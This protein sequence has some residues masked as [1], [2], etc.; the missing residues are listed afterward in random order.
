MSLSSRREY[1]GI[2]QADYRKA[3]RRERSDMLDEMA[4]VTGLNRKYIIQ[5]MKTDLA[6]KP[7]Q[8]QRG[9][10]YGDEVEEA[11]LYVADC[12]DFICG[13]RLKPA[14]LFTAKSLERHGEMSLSPQVETSLAKISASTIDRIYARNRDRVAKRLPRKK[15]SA[16][17]C[18]LQ[19]VPM[20]M[21]DWDEQ[22]PGHLEVDTVFH[23]GGD[24]SG[25]FVYTIQAIDVATGWSER[26]AVLGKSW[27][28]MQDALTAIDHRLPFPILEIH[29]DNG[30]EFL[31][32]HMLRYW[33]QQ[34]P[35][36]RLSRNR[37]WS[38]NDSRFVEQKNS[39]LVRAFLERRRFDTVAQTWAINYLYEIMELYYNFFQPVF[40]TIEKTWTEQGG[41]PR[42]K[43]RY[44]DPQTPLDRLIATDTLD[45]DQQKY[46]L[47]LRDAIN[48]RWLKLELEDMISRI[49]AM[50]NALSSEQENVYH[51]QAK[52]RP[53]IKKGVWDPWSDS[54]LTQPLP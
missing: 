2:K 3:S 30:S 37:P 14:L 40:K 4:Q 35:G 19:A 36:V 1:L 54:H 8:R 47:Q 11:V 6:R 49:K 34:V 50:P 9:R 15:P 44:E 28:V 5:L 53:L 25:D 42:P 41:R 18:V 33:P 43:R 13:K 27:I 46:L 20:S 29:T 24:Q 10:T 21:I 23:S 31:N 7:R 26:Y 45:D 17:S 22:E 48:V 52:Y 38:K 51:T 16:S 32:G 39:S 12:L